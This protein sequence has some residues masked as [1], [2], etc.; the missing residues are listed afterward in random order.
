[1]AVGRLRLLLPHRRGQGQSS[2]CRRSQC[3][4]RPARQARPHPSTHP[5]LH[6]SIFMPSIDSHT[7]PQINLHPQ[8]YKYVC[9]RKGSVDGPE[10]VI[11][12]LNKVLTSFLFLFWHACACRLGDCPRQSAPSLT[13]AYGIPNHNSWPRATRTWMWGT[14]TRPP[15]ST[16]SSATAPTP[17]ATRRVRK[18]EGTGPI[19][20]PMDGSDHS[21]PLGSTPPP[22][23]PHPTTNRRTTS[24]SR[25]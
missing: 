16:A 25:T 15:A 18:K 1:M 21:P 20:C 24:G 10:E 22:S 23:R 12:D 19:D 17:R 13:M 3:R 6:S 2:Q 8:S 5:S 4:R 9:R 11:L 7:L 14:G